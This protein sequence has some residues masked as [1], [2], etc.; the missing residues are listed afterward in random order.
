MY[1]YIEIMPPSNSEKKKSHCQKASRKY[2]GSK[3]YKLVDRVRWMFS[4]HSNV[5]RVM[6]TRP[7]NH[8]SDVRSYGCFRK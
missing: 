5:S 1:I 8:R 3:N 7:I 6:L 2:L 4:Q